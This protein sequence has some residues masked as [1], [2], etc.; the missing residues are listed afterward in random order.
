LLHQL[1]KL[2]QPKQQKQQQKQKQQKE[3]V[4][5]EE[6]S[7]CGC[8]KDEGE[9]KK[10]G[11][12][13]QTKDDDHQCGTAEAEEDADEDSLAGE[14]D[15]D[16]DDYPSDTGE[17]DA[18]DYGDKKVVDLEDMGDAIAASGNKGK[19]KENTA[20]KEMVTPSQA[21]AL[22][23]EGY[24]LNGPNIS[25]VV[26]ADATSTRST[27]LQATSAWKLHRVWPVP[28]SV[29]FAGDTTRTQWPRSGNGRRTTR[30]LLSKQL[31]TCISQ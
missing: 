30:T 16:T 20:P 25:F 5:A 21:V 2:N 13:C 28:T 31:S 19:E 11:G 6:P 18:D 7:P 9:E 22:K 26:E 1:P 4:A 10:E 17:D 12:C 3:T 29:S 8:G 15:Y 27:V 24:K 23:K 14:H